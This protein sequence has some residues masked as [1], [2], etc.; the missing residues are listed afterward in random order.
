MTWVSNTMQHDAIRDAGW[1]AEMLA[2]QLRCDI[3]SA[4]AF[5]EH[6]TALPREAALH[7]Q[8]WLGHHVGRD[9]AGFQ[10]VDTAPKTISMAGLVD[11]PVVHH[12]A[13]K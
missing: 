13:R 3:A 8:T 11:H 6:G 5:L 12:G 9:H 4:A 10:Y 7:L 2:P 1:T